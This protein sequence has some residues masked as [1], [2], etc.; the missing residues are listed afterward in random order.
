MSKNTIGA[1][2]GESWTP[3]DTT[4]LTR[5]PRG[6]QVGVAGNVSLEYENGDIVTWPACVAG[7]LHAHSGFV[8]IRATG[9]TATSIVIA[10]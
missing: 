5:T 3:S 8:K 9:T 6:F 1:T 2:S 4:K 10:Y 7:A